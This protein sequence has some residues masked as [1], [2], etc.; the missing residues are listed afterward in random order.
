MKTVRTLMAVQIDYDRKLIL[1]ADQAAVVLKAIQGAA[2]YK[3]T[4]RAEGGDG[5]S[6]TDEVLRI[7]LIRED[8]VFDS[9]E[10]LKAANARPEQE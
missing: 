9:E 5:F 6:P 3:R 1:T 10:A 8:Q 4:Y 7:E 2:I